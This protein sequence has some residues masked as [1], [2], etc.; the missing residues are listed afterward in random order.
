MGALTSSVFKLYSSKAY[1]KA[2]HISDISIHK[3][4]RPTCVYNILHRNMSSR[5]G[6]QS[7]LFECANCLAMVS[8]SPEYLALG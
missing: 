3:D 4:A 8:E 7:M 6:G 1:G 2:C 5:Q